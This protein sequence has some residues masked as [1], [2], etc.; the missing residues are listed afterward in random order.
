MSPQVPEGSPRVLY[1][2]AYLSYA[3]PRPILYLCQ[4]GVAALFSS[5]RNHHFQNAARWARGPELKGPARHI[6]TMMISEVA[7]EGRIY[8]YGNVVLLGWTLPILDL[9]YTYV[10]KESPPSL[11]FF[12]NEHSQNAARWA[13]GPHT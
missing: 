1:P 10:N 5:F 2:S 6:L 7:T 11:V 3:Y 4:Q 13:R 9:S 8:G 12:R